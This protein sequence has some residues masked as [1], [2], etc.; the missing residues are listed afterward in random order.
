MP[1]LL[2]DWE[3]DWVICATLAIMKYA[4]WSVITSTGTI[5][6]PG[7]AI[8]GIPQSREVMEDVGRIAMLSRLL[9][10][11]TSRCRWIGKGAT[12]EHLGDGECRLSIPDDVNQAVLAYERRRP[13][14]PPWH[15][16]GIVPVEPQSDVGD[17]VIAGMGVVPAMVQ[18]RDMGVATPT[19]Y[20]PVVRLASELEYAL[21]P[22]ERAIEEQYNLPLASILHTF[23]AIARVVLGRLPE[24]TPETQFRFDQNANAHDFAAGMLIFL[25]VF[26]RGLFT[27]PE[28]NLR[29]ELSREVCPPWSNSPE[30]AASHVE[31]FFRVFA[32]D[33]ERR[34]QIDVVQRLP[35]Y[36][37]LFISPGGSSYI[38]LL[39]ISEFYRDLVLGARAWAGKVHGDLFTMDVRRLARRIPGV[40]TLPKIGGINYPSGQTGEIDVPLLVGRRLYAVECKAYGKNAALMSGDMAATNT[41]TQE[42]REWVSQAQRAAETLEVQRETVEPKVSLDVTEIE[43]VVC[44]AGQ[45]FVCPEARY[46]TLGTLPRVCTVEELL[47]HLKQQ[48]EQANA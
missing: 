27:L 1:A 23:A 38:D 15:E 34:R 2:P 9:A 44:T 8:Q 43:W 6:Q 5:V 10:V 19:A 7:I 14:T 18:I 12:L 22:Y 41:R 40:T 25:N 35:F 47:Q 24:H 21:S 20:V 29:E 32:L 39:A 36:R 42:I 31:A 37:F 30:Q 28:R 13:N 4:S 48:A 16:I 3:N 33:A 11:I 45:E 17:G 26:Q 46:G